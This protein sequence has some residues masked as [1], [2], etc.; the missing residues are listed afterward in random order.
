M[1]VV[2]MFNRFVKKDKWRIAEQRTSEIQP[3]RIPASSRPAILEACDLHQ[4]RPTKR[5]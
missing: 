1:I 5:A 4:R 3:L 2:Q